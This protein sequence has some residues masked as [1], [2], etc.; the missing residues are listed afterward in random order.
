MAKLILSRLPINYAVWR[1]VGIFRNGAMNQAEYAIK[2]FSLH[3]MRCFPGGIFPPGLVILELGPGDSIASAVI[4]DAYGVAKTYLIDAGNYAT[5]NIAFYKS[6]SECLNKKNIRASDF[7]TDSSFNSLLKKY[8]ATYLTRGIESLRE[9]PDNSVDMIWS[10][11]VLEHIRAHELE[12]ILEQLNR[13]LKPGGKFSH[14]IDYQDH[15]QGALNNL[16]FPSWLWESEIFAKSG[17]YTNRVPAV[18]MHDLCKKLGVTVLNEEFGKWPKM[19]TNRKWLAKEFDIY[20]D[21][22]LLNRT[23][24]ILGIKNL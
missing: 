5:K 6:L 9:I 13:I 20:S 11:S 2:I 23:S 21:Q 18:A 24:H 22:I 19:P 7:D 14:N 8:K 1:M 16:R 10:H 12:D 4:A 3:A 15:L 17:F